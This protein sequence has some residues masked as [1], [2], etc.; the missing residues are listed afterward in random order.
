MDIDRAGM[1]IGIDIGVHSVSGGLFFF[2]TGINSFGMDNKPEIIR[3]L[4]ETYAQNRSPE[5]VISIITGMVGNLARNYDVKSVGIS[6]PGIIDAERAH[7]V[8]MVNFSPDWD[9]FN[10]GNAARISLFK[11]EIDVP[12]DVEN[13]AN[14]YALGEGAAGHAQEVKNYVVITLRTGIGCGIIV[15]GRLLLGS[16]GMAGESGHIV[17]GGDKPCRCGGKGHPETIAGAGEISGRAALKRLPENFAALWE[18]RESAE[19]REILD[20]SVDAI[21]RMTASIA[22]IL[23]PEMIIFGGGISLTKGFIESVREHIKPYLSHPFKKFMDY[24][25]SNLGFDA[26]LYGAASLWRYGRNSKK[27]N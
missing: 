22:H 3:R 20:E 1:R 6:L 27:N 2:P 26:P 16:H 25:V 24:R 13:D 10:L 15:N 19:A 12:V 5:G 8:E 18:M 21:S 4:G 17:T 23:D 11:H 7:S 14:C 9:N